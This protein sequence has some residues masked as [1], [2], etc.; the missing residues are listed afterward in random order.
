MLDATTGQNGILQTKAFMEAAQITGL[1]ITKMDGT[2]KGGIV[3]G[4]MDQFHIPVKYVGTG[5]Q[6]GDIQI[7][8]TQNFIEALFK[9]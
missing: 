7:F 3:I 1:V 6:M 8:N 4:I 5:E 2:A 9:E